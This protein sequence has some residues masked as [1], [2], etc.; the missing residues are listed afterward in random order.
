MI[1]VIIA[2]DEPLAQQELQFMLEREQDIEIVA[3]ASNGQEALDLY[4]KHRP[5]VMFLDIEMPKV[6]GIDV[7]RRIREMTSQ[8][9]QFVF[10]TAYDDYAL[11]AFEME[12]VDY[13]QKPYDDFRFMAM[14]ERLKKRL[15]PK[16]R[17]VAQ[18][19]KLLIEHDEKMIAL[20]PD[21]IYFAVPVDR[22]LEISTTRGVLESK[23]TLRELEETLDHSSFFRPHRSYLVN[24]NHVDEIT[25]WFNGAYNLT[26]DDPEQTKIPVSRS[27]RKELF[28]HFRSLS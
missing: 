27:A 12:A 6:K 8:A 3:I 23:L 7:A 10:I 22:M 18:K 16:K 20:T 1:R 28:E 11:D 4:A 5:D 15:T 13:L 25:P 24:L 9:P 21:D 2:E 17:P 19:G 14:I 26:M